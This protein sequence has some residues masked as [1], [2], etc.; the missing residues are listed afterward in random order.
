MG[1][2]GVGKCER[3]QARAEFPTE[4]PC[5]VGMLTLG[6]DSGPPQE[7]VLG[8]LLHSG[9][10]ERLPPRTEE[11]SCG[12]LRSPHGF[13]LPPPLPHH[14]EELSHDKAEEELSQS[15]TEPPPLLPAVRV[16]AQDGA[17]TGGKKDLNQAGEGGFVIG[18][19]ELTIKGSRWEAVIRDL[20]VHG[21]K[22]Q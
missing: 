1:Y 7:P 18:G 19:T 9:Q 16:P 15:L 22:V 5:A 2:P 10:C 20:K 8:H 6:P 4:S 21:R 17:R 11:H 13:P 14:S 3:G 12:L